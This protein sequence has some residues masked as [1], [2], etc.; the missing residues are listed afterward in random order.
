M[1]QQEFNRIVLHGTEDELY[2]A[3]L[4]HPDLLEVCAKQI[5][6][7]V[8]MMIA[9]TDEFW[10]QRLVDRGLEEVEEYNYIEDI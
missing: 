3:A 9:P 7:D 6:T 5:E 1:T 2:E 4:A 8:D 10:Y